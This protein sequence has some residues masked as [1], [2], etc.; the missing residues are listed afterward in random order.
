MNFEGIGRTGEKTSE[1]EVDGVYGEGF[2]LGSPPENI[3]QNRE[4]RMC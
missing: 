1:G 4:T 2:A 3:F